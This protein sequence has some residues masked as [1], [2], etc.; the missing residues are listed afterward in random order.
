MPNSSNLKHSF[1]NAAGKIKI[2]LKNDM[3]FHIAMSRSNKA[4]KSLVCALMGLREQDV[5]SVIITNPIDYRSYSGKEIILDVKVLLNNS[6]VL[7]IELQTYADKEW[8]ERSLLYLCR[9]FDNISKGDDYLLIKPT[10]FIAIMDY[11]LFPEFPEF[12]AHFKLLNLKY[13]Y[14]YSSKFNLN[15]L[16]LNRTELAEAKDSPLVSWARLF[17]AATWEELKSLSES[18]KTMQEVS[19]IM[20]D[21]NVIQSEEQTILEGRERFRAMQRAMYRNGYDDA[22]ET[23]DSIIAAKDSKISA[24]TSEL[25]SKDSRIAELEAQLAAMKA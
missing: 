11:D 4:L 24:I 5:K 18:D 7:D 23:Y 17:Q 9:S 21:S 16:S 12:Y 14:P 2:P 3:M 20:Y 19:E 25:S 1:H 10:T 22:K 6:E 8:K 13:G 15:V